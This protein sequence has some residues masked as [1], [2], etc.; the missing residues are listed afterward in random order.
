MEAATAERPTHDEHGHDHRA[1]ERG[2]ARVSHLAPGAILLFALIA[3]VALVGLVFSADDA[4]HGGYQCPLREMTGV[5]CPACGA[6]RAF[7]HL[8][9]GDMG[10]LHYNWAWPVMWVL[11]IG[12][13]LVL[14]RRGWRKE[15]L[16]GPR[17]KAAWRRLETMRMRWVVATPFIL[18]TPAWIVALSNIHNINSV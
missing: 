3:P 18:L 8:A 11:A 1:H 12:W 7:F 9:N 13:A 6:T 17:F 2:P 5:P 16:R 4:D 10:F 14:L 15:P